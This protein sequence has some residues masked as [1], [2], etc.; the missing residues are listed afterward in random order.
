MKTQGA[1]GGRTCLPCTGTLTLN[2]VHPLPNTHCSLL[3]LCLICLLVFNFILPV[4]L[5]GAGECPLFNE[6]VHYYLETTTNSQGRE[7]RVTSLQ[8]VTGISEDSLINYQ[9]G[10]GG[11]RSIGQRCSE[12]KE[13]NSHLISHF[14]TILLKF[15]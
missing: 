10:L 15:T 4:G 3:F 5:V 9:N 2:A 1:Q 8:S 12:C 14:S 6:K 11:K 13:G 7:S